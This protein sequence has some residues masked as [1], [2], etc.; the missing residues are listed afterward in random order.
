MH[1]HLELSPCGN[2]KLQTVSPAVSRLRRT[3]PPLGF[4]QGAALLLLPQRLARC[5]GVDFGGRRGLQRL[6]VQVQPAAG[7]KRVELP[8]LAQLLDRFTGQQFADEVLLVP[9]RENDQFARGVVHPCADHRRIPLPAVGADERRIGFEGVLVE[10]VEDKTIDA[11]A[12]ERT[13]AAHRKQA[14]PAADDLDLVGRADI[15]RRP[16]SALDR[17]SGEKGGVFARLENPLHAAV[18]LRGQRPGVGGDRHAAVGIQPQH[19]G[20]KQG[21]GADAFAVLGR[22]GD[23][24]PPDAPRGEGLQHPV[25][26]TVE[27]PQVEEGIDPEGEIG[28]RRRRRGIRIGQHRSSG[29]RLF[30]RK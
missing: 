29:K 18:E 30:R 6:E 7:R 14:A 3:A 20:R 4:E 21:R 19:I 27:R 16:G 22:H 1:A 17:R 24:Q 5:A 25:V 13:F 28:E 11:V 10:V 8:P 23:D 12:R 26:G 9:A 15:A 2:T